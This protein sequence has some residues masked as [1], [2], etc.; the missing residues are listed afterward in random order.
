MK[1]FFERFESLCRERGE[2]TTALGTQLGFSKSTI[3]QWRNGKTAP[4]QKSL[5]RLADYFDVSTD[6]LLGLSGLRNPDK[7]WDDAQKI[8]Q[9]VFGTTD[10]PEHAWKDFEKVVGRLK[11]KYHIKAD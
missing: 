6:Y 5:E 8:K 4:N 1:T 7:E 3:S 9:T 11:E 10:I 2:K